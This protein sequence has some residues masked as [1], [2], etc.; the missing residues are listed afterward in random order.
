MSDATAIARAFYQATLDELAAVHEERGPADFAEWCL[1]RVWIKDKLAQIV[2]FN[3]KQVQ[4]RYLA[5]KNAYL[6]QGR[7]ARFLVLKAR[8]FGITTL[9]QALSYNLTTTRPN[10]RC[11]TLAR[12]TEQ[13]REIFE[14]ALRMFER[15]PNPPVAKGHGNTRRLEFPELGSTFSIG[16]AGAADFGRG[17]TI[18]RVHGSEVSRWLRGPNQVSKQKDLIAGLTEA[19]ANGEVVLETTA[20]GTE[21]FALEW[22]RA[23][24]GQGDWNPIFM[25]WWDDPLYTLGLTPEEREEVGATL[26][27]R[28]RALSE[29]HQLTLGQIAWRR[30]RIADLG[31]LFLQEYPEDDESCFRR[32]GICFF[33]VDVIEALLAATKEGTKVA[34]PGGYRIIW[35]APT[36]GDKYVIGVDTSEGIA[37]GDLNGVAVLS[38]EG[39]RQVAAVHGLFKPEELAVHVVHMAKRY[40]N[41]YVGIERNNHGHAVL[42]A[43]KSL[44]LKGR[45]HLYHFAKDRVGWDTS[46]TTR[47]ILLDALETAL[48]K[49]EME[50]RHRDFLGECLSFRKQQSGKYEADDGAHDDLVFMW[51]IAL[52]MHRAKRPRI[53]V[54]VVNR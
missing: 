7:K 6:R 31:G 34:I 3:V 18:Q 24:K 32:S 25:P 40:N 37:G 21:W 23:K 19:A 2:R 27:D 11:V 28:E 29:N 36:A 10:Q 20:Y 14:I 4:L 5:R 51:G 48:R 33:D 52:Q 42:V 41:A 39:A 15:D 43:V 12:T 38:K 44:G 9:E 54:M 49:G 16:T 45:K 35:E 47:P 53:G 1:A 30:D 22:D 50:I 13:T 26:T 8:Q 17:T 46:G